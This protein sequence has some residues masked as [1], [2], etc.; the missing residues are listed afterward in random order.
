MIHLQHIKLKPQHQSHQAWARTVNQHRLPSIAYNHLVKSWQKKLNAVEDHPTEHSESAPSLEAFAAAICDV[1]NS[2]YLIDPLEEAEDIP[3]T[4]MSEWSLQYNAETSMKELEAQ[5]AQQ[6]QHEVAEALM[7]WG[8][9]QQ[10]DLHMLKSHMA[11]EVHYE[12][13][14]CLTHQR[15]VLDITSPETR[16]V[17]TNESG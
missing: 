5:Q 11:T 3:H 6:A 7:H 16:S 15:A 8:L 13:V 9:L 1:S 14:T 10:H 4:T 2:P 12:R 17:E